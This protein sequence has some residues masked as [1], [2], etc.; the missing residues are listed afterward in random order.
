MTRVIYIVYWGALEPLGQSLVVPMVKELAGMGVDLTLVTFE[1]P[2][3]LAR[4][5]EME[6]VSKMFAKYKIEWI[7]LK[8]HKDPKIPAT[9]LDIAYGLALSLRKR[10]NKRFDV[11]HARTYVGG[12]VGLALAPII[13]AKFVYHNEGFYPDEQVD[14]GV[15]AKNSRPHK[16]AKRLENIMYSRADGVIALSSRA[17]TIIEKLPQVSRKNTP[18]ILVPSCVDLEKFSL[19]QHKSPP[20]GEE[21]KF[22]YIGSVGGRYILDNIGRFIW[23]ARKINEK[24]F[25]QIYSKANYDEVK[26]TL[27]AANLPEEA[28]SLKALSSDEV[29][30]HLSKHHV[31]IHFLREGISEHTGSPTKIGEYWAL[32]LPVIITPNMSDNDL[33]VQREKVGV[34]IK[35]H[36]DLSYLEAFNELKLLLKDTDLTAR[37]RRAAE[38]HYSLDLACKDIYSLYKQ[39]IGKR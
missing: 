11:V 26:K 24:I 36:T 33:V 10:L 14:C 29:P 38:T 13:G 19:P 35:D 16:I 22:V 32:G 1:K 39:L 7:P 23:A 15:W 3:D 6:R 28:W 12:L 17:K 34:V 25:L 30:Q 37:C 31:G 21:I 9:F 18:V 8:Y 4:D 2:A 27:S 5:G 20:L